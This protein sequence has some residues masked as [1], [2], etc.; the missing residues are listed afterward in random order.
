M[1]R[2]SLQHAFVEG[3][4][5]WQDAQRLRPVTACGADRSGLK[6]TSAQCRSYLEQNLKARLQWELEAAF[7]KFESGF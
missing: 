6:K 4:P 2:N 5:L 1:S 3:A 7:T